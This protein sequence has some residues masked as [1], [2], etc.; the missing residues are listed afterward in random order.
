MDE[1]LLDDESLLVTDIVSLMQS[2]VL[3]VDRVL[4]GS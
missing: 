1:T 2:V 4:S 3:L